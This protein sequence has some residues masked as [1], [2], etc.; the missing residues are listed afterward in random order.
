VCGTRGCFGGG[1]G[2][3]CV[4]VAEGKLLQLNEMIIEVTA[5]R[6]IIRHGWARLAAK[7]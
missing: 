7:L 5:S 1:E 3:E 6:K 4:N 2:G